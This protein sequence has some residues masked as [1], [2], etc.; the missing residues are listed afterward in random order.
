MAAAFRSVSIGRYQLDGHQE[1]ASSREH[2]RL[3]IGMI[4]DGVTTRRVQN[5][6]NGVNQ[7][8]LIVTGLVIP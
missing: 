6:I 7:S 5:Y 2:Q 3:W 8:I 1:E 4:D